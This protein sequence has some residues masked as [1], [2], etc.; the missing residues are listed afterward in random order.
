MN[1]LQVSPRT[2]T[3]I[4]RICVEAYKPANSQKK[5][6]MFSASV[7]VLQGTE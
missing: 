7:A 3:T 2:K 4:V 6:N 1:C 5:E